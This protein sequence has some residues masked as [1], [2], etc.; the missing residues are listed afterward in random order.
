M[1]FITLAVISIAA[2]GMA[3][4]PAGHTCDY[5]PPGAWV[6][7]VEAAVA[8]GEIVDPAAKRLPEVAP[9]TAL[10]GVDPTPCLSP[11]HVF[12]HEDSAQ[13]LL[14]NFSDGQLLNLMADGANALM[15]AHGDNFDFI[16]YWLNYVPHHTI[17]AAFYMPIENDVSG[18]GDPSTV[19]TPIFN[20]RVSL[21]V[22][23][24]NVEGYIMM[25]N[26]NSGTWAPGT[27]GDAFFTR[28]ALG[29]ELAHR[30]AMYLPDLLGGQ[31]LQG[32]NGSCGRQFHWNFRVDG[33]GSS[34]EIA[35]WTGVSPANLS[36]AGA[37]FNLDIPGSVFSYTDLYLMGYVSP[38]EMDAGNSDLRYM[39]NS[40]CGGPY[41]GP[42]TP[43][44]SA[45]I[46]ASAG[47]RVPDS[48]A[49]QKHFRMGWVMFHL[50][51]DAPDGLELAKA[52]GIHEQHM[53]DWS[54]STLGRGTINNQL[55]ND[56]NC[57]DL[58]D[59][60]DVNG[61]GSAD[62]NGNGIPDECECLGDL[63]G[64][65]EIDINDFLALLAAWG[66]NPGHAADL[67][68]DGTVGIADF[69]LLLANWGPCV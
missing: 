44:S 14:T 33:Q 66:P 37:N 9:R 63:D 1:R 59:E 35:E 51:G 20:N 12:P 3:H 57:N 41:N 31:Q 26:I 21:G 23:G 5:R 30:F 61:G 7:E 65:D 43:M 46:I 69:L 29:Q 68:N 15:A 40:N 22:N 45:D 36:F 24:D 17:G 60:D 10:A 47:P 6:A 56:C 50:P 2:P 38:A 55:F 25:W 54:Y 34:M 11:L 64:D 52:I 49:S 27:G 48:T 28:I 39:N 19:G 13:V 42:I 58:A 62:V 18:I 32:N 16:G 8:R 53:I 4:P 67:D